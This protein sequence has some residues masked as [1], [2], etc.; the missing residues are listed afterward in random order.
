MWK[1]FSLPYCLIFFQ[2]IYTDVALDPYSS[3]GH[4][5]IVREDGKLSD[6]SILPGDPKSCEQMQNMVPSL[7][8]DS[9][10]IKIIMA[11][12]TILD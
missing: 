9:M 12:S 8:Y 4:D 2:V 10:K 5:G 11:A 3:D 1:F 6:F 7:E